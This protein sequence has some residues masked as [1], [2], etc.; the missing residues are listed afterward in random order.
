MYMLTNDTSIENILR[1]Q[2]FLARHSNI[3]IADTENIPDF[4]RI[5]YV[6]IV[7]EALKKENE[8]MENR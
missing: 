4:E 6:G 8:A 7:A 3:G 5:A 2:A 1:E